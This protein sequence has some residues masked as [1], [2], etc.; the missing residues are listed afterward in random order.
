M[1]GGEVMTSILIVDDS[2]FAR[3]L[4]AGSLSEAGLEVVSAV[5][6]AGEAVLAA[7]EH[8]PHSALLD[9]NLGPGPNGIDLAQALRRIDPAVGIVILTTY[10]DPRL[11]PVDTESLPLG[12]VYV[13][14]DSV[15]DIQ[16]LVDAVDRS[17]DGA[18]RMRISDP[19]TSRELT[20]AQADVLRMI[21][22]GMSNAE[23]ARR[24]GVSERTVENTIGR[25]ALRFGLR[26]SP[27][28][29]LRVKLVRAYQSLT[30]GNGRA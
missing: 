19:P 4:L 5:A 27:D 6:T 10:E 12:S 20:D 15:T 18:S 23:I 29:N 9:L 24:R 22:E 8:Q 28:S 2:E 1:P 14:K 17:I 7:R 3:T 11:L 25:I 30:A 26:Q 21:A 16:V 13:I